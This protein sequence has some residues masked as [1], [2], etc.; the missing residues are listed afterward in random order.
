MFPKRNILHLSTCAIYKDIRFRLQRSRQEHH[1]FIGTFFSLQ[2]SILDFDFAWHK[3]AGRLRPPTVVRLFTSINDGDKFYLAIQ[4]RLS[5]KCD[6]LSKTISLAHS[7]YFN[8]WQWLIEVQSTGEQTANHKSQIWNISV[9][10]AHNCDLSVHLWS[11]R[12]HQI[13]KCFSVLCTG[14]NYEPT[15]RR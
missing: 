13:P 14:W 9:K 6:N 11:I 2:F 3:T 12:A 10:T 15:D 1:S 5:I 8:N 7:L 4:V